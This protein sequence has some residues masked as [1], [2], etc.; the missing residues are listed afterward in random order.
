MSDNKPNAKT[1]LMTLYSFIDGMDHS[2]GLGTHALRKY[3][4]SEQIQT[5]NGAASAPVRMPWW[6]L[7]AH[8]SGSLPS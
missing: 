8:S 4:R 5:P 7:W 6:A 2:E 1:A 3:Q